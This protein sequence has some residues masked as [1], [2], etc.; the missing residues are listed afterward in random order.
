MTRAPVLLLAALAGVL[1]LFA[2]GCSRASG[3]APPSVPLRAEVAAVLDELDRLELRLAQLIER[4][5]GTACLV[6]GASICRCESLPDLSVHP[7]PP[8]AAAWRPALL[9]RNPKAA[10]FETVAGP[11]GPVVA[12]EGR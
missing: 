1:I 9:N 5:R 7:V 3:A 2:S 11:S 6:G 10:R 12:M 8:P 4:Q